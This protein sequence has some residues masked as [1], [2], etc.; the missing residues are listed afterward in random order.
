MI[1]KKTRLIDYQQKALITCAS[2][3][4]YFVCDSA[5]GSD[6]GGEI[7]DRK[8]GWFGGILEIEGLA[9]GLL[10]EGNNLDYFSLE[11]C[12]FRLLV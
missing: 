4:A 7:D 10:G 9:T 11:I 2:Q 8:F 5:S 3:I 6:Y 1:F 12:N